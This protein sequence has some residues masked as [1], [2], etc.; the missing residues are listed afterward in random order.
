MT[1]RSLMKLDLARGTSHVS[2]V[3]WI[4]HN[5]WRPHDDSWS[6]RW[7]KIAELFRYQWHL[8]KNHPDSEFAMGKWAECRS[9]TH[10]EYNMAMFHGKL[11][12]DRRV[13]WRKNQLNMGKCCKIILLVGQT[14]INHHP[15]ITVFLGGMLAIPRLGGANGMIFPVQ[16]VFATN[17]SWHGQKLNYSISR[18][19]VWRPNVSHHP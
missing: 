19:W 7:P 2:G 17:S 1:K 8:K 11:W 18:G 4:F 13:A 16:V 5:S 3:E 14:I 6:E 12:I 15:V 9:F 10:L